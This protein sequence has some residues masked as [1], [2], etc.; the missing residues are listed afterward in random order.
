MHTDEPHRIIQSGRP[1]VETAPRSVRT[2][3]PL[4]RVLLV[5]RATLLLV[6]ATEV[7]VRHGIEQTV[8]SGSPASP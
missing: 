6:T 7:C 4:R 2:R 1:L 5:I 3:R 8:A